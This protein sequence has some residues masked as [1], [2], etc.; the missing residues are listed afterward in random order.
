MSLPPRHIRRYP[1]ASTTS[2]SS[3]TAGPGSLE[4]TG[5]ECLKFN[6]SF[7]CAKKREIAHAADWH[8]MCIK[9]LARAL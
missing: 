7:P 5:E 4:E 9:G 3:S 2:S 6:V 8:G 1:T